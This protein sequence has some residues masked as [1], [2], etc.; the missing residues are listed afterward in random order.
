MKSSFFP[1]AVAHSRHCMRSH[2]C[3]RGRKA[4]CG[5]GDDPGTNSILR[6][7]VLTTADPHTLAL[8]A[9]T[10][11]LAVC[12]GATLLLHI[13]LNYLFIFTLDLGFVGAA[14]ANSVSEIVNLALLVLYLNL[15]TT[16]ILERTW[17]GWSRDCLQ[18][19]GAFIA[20]AVPACLMTWYALAPATPGLTALPLQTLVA[21]ILWSRCDAGLGVR[22]SRVHLKML[23]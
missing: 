8:Q 11:P 18:D 17:A 22:C 21:E 12:S 13:P 6:T 1:A 7:H 16:G 14:V 9:I 4:L 2:V 19:W 15:E 10:S 5:Y 20:L 3:I 23:G